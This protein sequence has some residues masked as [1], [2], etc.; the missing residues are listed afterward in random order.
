MFSF[1][2]LRVSP[3]PLWENL[4]QIHFLFSYDPCVTSELEGGAGY[5]FKVLVVRSLWVWG[6]GETG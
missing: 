5:L 1:R 4:C 3:S 6:E 2:M